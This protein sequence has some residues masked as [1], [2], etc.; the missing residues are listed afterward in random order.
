MAD[1]DLI[2]CLYP[3]DGPAGSIALQAIEQLN[4]CRKGVNDSISLHDKKGRLHVL[5]I[6]AAAV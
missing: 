2:A 5:P 4:P 3:A 6:L 1:H